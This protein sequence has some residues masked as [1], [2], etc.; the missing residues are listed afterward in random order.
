VRY[1]GLTPM[2]A[3]VAG[4]RTSAELCGLADELGTLQ[5]G[6][7]ADVVVVRGNPLDDIDALGRP[8]NILAVLKEGKPVQNRGGLLP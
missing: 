6:K 2:E 3:I 8:E 1:G 4:T 7:L 5:A